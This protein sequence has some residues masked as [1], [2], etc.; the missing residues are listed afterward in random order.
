MGDSIET[1][2]DLLSEHD[3]SAFETCS[4]VS[5]LPR[6]KKS[7]GGVAR[8]VEGTPSW[9]ESGSQGFS[10]MSSSI[11]ILRICIRRLAAEASHTDRLLEGS[12]EDLIG[13]RSSS[14]ENVAIMLLPTNSLETYRCIAQPAKPIAS[15]KETMTKEFRWQ[16]PPEVNHT[17]FQ[18]ICGL[19]VHS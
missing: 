3:L 12:G 1:V 15:I 6:R 18:S 11:A 5:F 10:P 19:G 16:S 17:L 2:R 9:M 14:R 13:I 8:G 7:R 4:T